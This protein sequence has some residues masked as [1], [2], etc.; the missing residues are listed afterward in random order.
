MRGPA[1]TSG[2]LFLHR[3]AKDDPA[4]F[5][6]SVSDARRLVQQ[7]AD[8]GYDYVKIAELDDQP[9]FALMDEARIRPIPVVGHVPNYDLELER[10]LAERMSSIEHIEE[11]YRVHFDYEPDTS[12]IPAFVE[13]VRRS[14]VP[15]S[16]LIATEVIKNGLFTERAGYLTPERLAFIERYNGTAAMERGRETAV[17]E[18]TRR[19]YAEDRS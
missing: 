17:G 10:I 18:T 5:V 14:Q 9:F 1:I 15:I 4:R 12:K 2:S 6:G 3:H 8:E 19:G 7:Y 11:L 13:L 16:T